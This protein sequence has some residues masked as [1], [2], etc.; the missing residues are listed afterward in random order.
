MY[1]YHISNERC[2]NKTNQAMNNHMLLL[3]YYLHPS[4]HNEMNKDATY[5]YCIQLFNQYRKIVPNQCCA[6]S[7]MPFV[8]EVEIKIKSYVC[9]VLLFYLHLMCA[10]YCTSMNANERHHH[11]SVKRGRV[12]FMRW[13]IKRTYYIL[14]LD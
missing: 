1:W 6:K 8:A 9:I 4:S 13:L 10:A 3:A 12:L 11:V 14:Q 2:T 7:P 5:R